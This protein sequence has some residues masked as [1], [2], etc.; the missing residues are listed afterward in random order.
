M[1]DHHI[2]KQIIADL[3]ECE[4]ARFA[5]LKPANLDSNMFTYHLQSLIKQKL[6]TKNDAGK[7]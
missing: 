3:V 5:D 6:I 4:T 1:I 7:Y 2:Q